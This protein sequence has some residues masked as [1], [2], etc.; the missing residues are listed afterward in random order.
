MFLN[1]LRPFYSKVFIGINLDL[2]TCYLNIIRIKNNKIKQDIKTKTKL[3]NQAISMETLKLIDFYQKKYPFTYIGMMSKIPDQGAI[4][5]ANPQE[6]LNYGINLQ[7]I[8]FK[9]F[10]NTWTAY[11]D[12]EECKKLK[13]QIPEI[14]SLDCL[15]SPFISIFIRAQKT[16]KTVLYAIQE[17]NSLSIAICNHQCVFCGKTFSLQ[18]A[19]QTSNN[20]ESLSS[21]DH[22][23]HTLENGIENLDSSDVSTE[24]EV[25][26]HEEKKKIDELNDFMRA[27]FVA[28]ILENTLQEY[29]KSDQGSFVDEIVIFDT[30]GITPDSLKYIN[31]TL[32]IETKVRPLSISNEIAT[33]MFK[34][35]KR[36]TL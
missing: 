11:I 22:L 16:K 27:T 14:G 15:F 8:N 5:T 1:L 4:P 33:L 9:S 6:F 2:D 12:Q 28:G 30:Y 35:Y 24:D 19:I 20:Q 29:Y 36:G 23:L 34:E 26:T 10:Q 21:L 18:N 25:D 17:K 7:Q 13:N 31:E 3:V 32:M